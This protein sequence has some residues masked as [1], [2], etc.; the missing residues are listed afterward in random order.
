MRR[1]YDRLIDKDVV[2]II[3]DRLSPPKLG[4]VTG[5]DYSLG[6]TIQE[7]KTKAY[8]VCINGSKSPIRSCKK[9]NYKQHKIVMQYCYDRIMSEKP[10]YVQELRRLML[11]I[12]QVP[13]HNPSVN[14]CAFSQ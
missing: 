10:I 8:L 5:S 3:S 12:N 6:L 2:Y 9:F 7:K 11:D 13:G 1:H 4:I 14:T